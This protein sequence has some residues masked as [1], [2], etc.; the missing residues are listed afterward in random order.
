MAKQ[1]TQDEKD[2]E[3]YLEYQE[4]LKSTETPSAEQVEGML[5]KPIR[6]MDYQ[7]ANTTGP[8]IA[9]ALSKITGRNVAPG[10]DQGKVRKLEGDFPG[11]SEMMYNAGILRGEQAPPPGTDEQPL[12]EMSLNPLTPLRNLVN[13]FPAA[14]ST[15]RH[16]LGMGVDVAT[17]PMTYESMGASALARL[18]NL[19]K[20]APAAR[21]L[22][23]VFNPIEEFGKFR[24]A[25]NYGKAFEKLDEVAKDM[26]KPIMPS[27]T[28]RQ[29]GFQG[30]A[31]E[32]AH[33]LKVANKEAG[34]EIGNVLK[35]AASQGAAVDPAKMAAD[36]LSVIQDLRA[37]G[38]PEA[39]RLADDLERRA[40]KLWFTHAGKIPVDEANKLKTFM[41][42]QI[43]QA[44]FLAGDE[45]SISKQ[46][47]KAAANQL[48]DEIPKEV[49][50][51]DPT[52]AQ[53]LAAANRRFS[54]T[55]NN[56]F[57]K[58]RNWARTA[59]EMRGPFDFTQVDLMLLGA[60][61]MGGYLSDGAVG[62]PIGALALKSAGRHMLSTA[63]RTARGKLAQKMASTGGLLDSAVRQAPRS[64][65]EAIQE[66]QGAQ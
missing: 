3:E 57:K 27:E 41:D 12:T 58:A 59:P 62:I 10:V 49:S 22:N 63:G 24:E 20:L 9:K 47:Q 31:R 28:L 50:R 17:D 30:N 40:A 4:Y 43:K 23:M 1:K 13:Q 11:A 5:D 18:K 19:G 29:R 61:G 7:R 32:A 51:V 37:K 64:V 44:G 39:D 26:K 55:D 45:A 54:S 38:L 25:R 34:D 15:A 6:V 2:Y 65:W 46:G 56:L 33:E 53:R 8:L 14:R 52:L 48:R 42:K 36:Q 16:V 60:G 35:S 66:E 21:A